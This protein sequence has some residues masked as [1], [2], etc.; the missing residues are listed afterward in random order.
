MTFEEKCRLVRIHGAIDEAMG[1]TDPDVQDMTD[2]EIRQEEPL[3]WAAMQLAEMIGRG[4]WD[5]YLNSLAT[6]EGWQT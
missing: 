2:N 3:L 5:K 4:P 1:D 6:Q